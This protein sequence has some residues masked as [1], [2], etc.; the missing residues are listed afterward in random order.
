M[1]TASLTL[2]LTPH[3][4]AFTLLSTHPSHPVSVAN[5]PSTFTHTL[6]PSHSHSLHT[7]THVHGVI[8]VLEVNK[9]KA[10]RA[11]SLQERQATPLNTHT[12][13]HVRTHT[14]HTHYT[15]THTHTNTQAL[16]CVCC[17][18]TLS[19]TSPTSAW[20]LTHT[21]D[22]C[23]TPLLPGGLQH[24]TGS[25][26]VRQSEE[27]CAPRPMATHCTVAQACSTLHMHYWSLQGPVTRCGVGYDVYHRQYLTWTFWSNFMAIH[28]GVHR[29]VP[30]W[31]SQIICARPALC[32]LRRQELHTK[33]ART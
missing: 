20:C 33:E 23:C 24:S 30:A 31:L 11:S 22:H 18:S 7:V 27:G 6:H 15:Q 19:Y 21:D 14:T 25:V 12:D 4:I 29:Y 8:H 17:N 2:T 9:G 1:S 13:M 10:S 3:S 28:H 32:G 5:Y 26:A 16:L